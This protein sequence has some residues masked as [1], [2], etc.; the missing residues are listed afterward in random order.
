MREIKQYFDPI[1]DTLKSFAWYFA[2]PALQYRNGGL[3]VYDR[4]AQKLTQ[5]D[6]FGEFITRKISSPHEK[7]LEIASGTG[8]ISSVLSNYLSDVVFLDLSKPALDLLQNQK[9]VSREHPV[10]NASFYQNPFADESFQTI[11]CVGGYRYVRWQQKE[12]FWHEITRLLR[13]EGELLFAQ[14]KPRG[15]PIQG[16]PLDHNLKKYNLCTQS[17]SHFLPKIAFGPISV[18]TGEYE[19]VTYKKHDSYN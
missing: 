16:S 14:F 2:N 13:P 10:I 5:R 1:R 7:V 12:Q 6:D 11:V 4:A 15:V 19:L 18:R 8:L 9:R 17:V 3:I